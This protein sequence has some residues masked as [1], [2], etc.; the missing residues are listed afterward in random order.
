VTSPPAAGRGGGRRGAWLRVGSWA[1]FGALVAV[2]ATVLY[3]RRAAVG[4]AGGLPGLAPSLLAVAVYFTANALLAWN[5]SAIV[6]VAGPRLPFRTALWVWSVSQ[7]SR[8]TVTLAQVGSR[9]VVGRRYGVPATAGVLSTVLELTWM[10]MVTS[11]IVIVTVPWWLPLAGDA[12]WVMAAA[13]LPAA[14]IVAAVAHP[15]AMLRAV[16]ALARRPLV[17]RVTGGR[18]AGI[19][20]RVGVDRPTM[21]RFVAR[22]G[23]NTLLRHTAFLTL[24]A[25]VGGDLRTH[26]LTAVGTYALGS[27]AGTLAVFAPG[28]LGVREGIIAVALA[29]VIG[30]AQA[31]LL[32]AA[33]RLLELVAELSLLGVARLARGEAAPVGEGRPAG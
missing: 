8:Y 27:L 18:F 10:L 13:A 25:A 24:F 20:T 5:W 33:V 11:T 23:T 15:E 14:G 28:G 19:A 29:P 17:D 4:E 31:L 1:L 22:Y 21:W 26:A 6:A 30:G 2:A 32:S 9:A 7:I 12:R 3:E 16:D